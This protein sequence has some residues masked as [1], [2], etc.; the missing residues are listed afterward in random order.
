ML[1][2]GSLKWPDRVDTAIY[3]T[4]YHSVKQRHGRKSP[5]D[6]DGDGHTM[7]EEI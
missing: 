3:R 4:T 1:A 5:S 7:I 2:H 6:S